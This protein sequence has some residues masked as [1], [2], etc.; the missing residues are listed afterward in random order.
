MNKLQSQLESILFVSNKPLSINQLAKAT[1]ESESDIRTALGELLNSLKDN[2][3]VLLEANGQFQ[4]ATH[5]QNSDMVK[6]FLNADLREKLTEATVEVLAII[7][8]R[9]PIAK[10]E[11]EAIRGVNSQYSIRHLL[12][13]GLIEKISNPDDGRSNYYQVTTEFMQQLGLTSMADLP[14]FET[15]VSKISLP[16]TP[17]LSDE[18]KTAPGENP[19]A[20]SEI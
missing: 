16:Q 19:S 9:Q 11:I 12:M 18:N 8:Y 10:S 4:L 7:A 2:G 15:L 20:V 17:A 3:I 14:D 6:N 13:R 5:S 1:N